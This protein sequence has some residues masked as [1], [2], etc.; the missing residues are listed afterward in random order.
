MKHERNRTCNSMMKTG[1]FV[2]AAQ[3]LS[4]R[5]MGGASRSSRARPGTQHTHRL[6]VPGTCSVPQNSTYNVCA[7]TSGTC[8]GPQV[9]PRPQQRKILLRRR[10][11]AGAAQIP[12]VTV[13]VRWAGRNASGDTWEP[14]ERLTNCPHRLQTNLYL[15]QARADSSTAR[16]SCCRATAG[17][18]Q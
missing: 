15:P 1:L 11:G 18:S 12:H 16:R 2:L 4:P 5:W 8:T 17:P 3:W 7:R 6:N 9:G 14:L 13:L 10:C